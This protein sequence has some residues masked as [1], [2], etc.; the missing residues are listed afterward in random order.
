[1]ARNG[2]GVTTHVTHDLT[3][4]HVP[5]TCEVVMSIKFTLW[6]STQLLSYAWS[7]NLYA[8]NIMLNQAGCTGLFPPIRILPDIYA[9][10]K[11][12]GR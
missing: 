7:V 6:A 5:Q 4:Y 8:F 10:D 12:L 3:L 9:V 2:R 11:K 1:V